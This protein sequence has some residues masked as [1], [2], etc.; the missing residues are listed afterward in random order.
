MTVVS[1]LQIFYDMYQFPCHY[2]PL[3][4]ISGHGMYLK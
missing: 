3:V 4:D 2:K 1:V